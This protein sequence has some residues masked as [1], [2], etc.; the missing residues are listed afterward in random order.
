M[1]MLPITL[2][3]PTPNHPKNANFYILHCLSYLRRGLTKG[4]IF[5]VQVDRSKSQ[6]TDDKI[7]LK[8][9]WSRH[10][11]HFKN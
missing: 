7:S 3:D 11:T 10:V 1:V 6:P 9:T 5:G 4:F 8:G 2:A